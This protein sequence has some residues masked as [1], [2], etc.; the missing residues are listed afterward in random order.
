L[1]K[2]ISGQ[3]KTGI[4]KK[5]MLFA[6]FRPWFVLFRFVTLAKSHKWYLVDCF[7]SVDLQVVIVLCLFHFVPEIVQMEQGLVADFLHE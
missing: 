1:C 2:P 3:D 7:Y 6:I 5:W 4:S